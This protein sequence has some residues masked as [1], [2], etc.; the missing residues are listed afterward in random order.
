MNSVFYFCFSSPASAGV[1]SYLLLFGGAAFR[2]YRFLRDALFTWCFLSAGA[3][4][5]SGVEPEKSRGCS[6]DRF[7]GTVVTAPAFSRLLF[8]RNMPCGLRAP[9]RFRRRRAA[10][11]ARF[12][13]TSFSKNAL[14]TPPRGFP[15]AP[16]LWGKNSSFIE[17]LKAFLPADFCVS[18]KRKEENEVFLKPFSAFLRVSRRFAPRVVALR[19]E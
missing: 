8:P 7:G 16:F 11:I 6:H 10:E 19:A 14:G 15:Q 1:F 12:C 3:G 17:T 5:F 2:W 9:L 13:K 4:D 18:K